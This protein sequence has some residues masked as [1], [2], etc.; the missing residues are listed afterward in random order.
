MSKE[1][2]ER[3]ALI[4]KLEDKIINPQTAFVNNVLIGLLK[5]APAA[6]VVEVVRCKDC[7][8][9]GHGNDCPMFHLV[10]LEADHYGWDDVTM[11]E[12][13]CSYGERKGGAE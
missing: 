6:D 13:Y 11:D 1:Y 5:K 7:I 10:W 4:K 3:G 12:Y 9:R 8:H 2:I